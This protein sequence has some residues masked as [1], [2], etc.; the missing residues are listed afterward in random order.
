MSLVE[1]KTYIYIIVLGSRIILIISQGSVVYSLI[2]GDLEPRPKDETSPFVCMTTATATTIS[3]VL[4][5]I[6]DSW[7]VEENRKSRKST[8]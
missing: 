3:I 6:H 4:V 7:H 1:T 8:E 2:R 5:Y